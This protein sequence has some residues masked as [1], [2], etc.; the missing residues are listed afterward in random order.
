MPPKRGAGLSVGAELLVHNN[1]TIRPPLLFCSYSIK[2][3]KCSTRGYIDQGDKRL[4]LH[5]EAVVYEAEA[6]S[7]SDR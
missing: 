6:W 4:M 1:I 2:H 5:E 7:S 3:C